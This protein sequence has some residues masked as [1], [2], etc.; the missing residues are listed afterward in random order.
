MVIQVKFEEND[1]NLPVDFG[2]VTEVSHDGVQE[3]TG[4]Y[5][6]TPKVTAQT[7]PTKDKLLAQ[8]VTVKEIPYFDVSNTSGG[9]T[10]YIGNEV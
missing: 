7:L 8:D 1:Q 2:E 6:A 3:Y 10:V 5:E 9:S 4:P